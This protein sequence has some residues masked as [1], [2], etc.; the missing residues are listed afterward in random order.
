MN[1]TKTGS[2]EGVIMLLQAGADPNTQN[3]EGMTALAFGIVSGHMNVIDLLAPVTAAGMDQII[4]KLA[5][6]KLEIRG[7][8]EKY[9]RQI[10]QNQTP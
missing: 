5:Q 8:L 1:A 3:S 6:S 10:R 2:P 7:E 4:I 9:L